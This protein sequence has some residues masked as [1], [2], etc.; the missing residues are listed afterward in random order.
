MVQVEQKVIVE[1]TRE[2]DVVHWH[3]DGFFGDSSRSSRR[4]DHGATKKRGSSETVT[5]QEDY[6]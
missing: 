2:I 1:E 5:Q 3:K 4:P 6:P